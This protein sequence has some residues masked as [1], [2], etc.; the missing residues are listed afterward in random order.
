ML[1]AQSAG[2]PTHTPITEFRAESFWVLGSR[3][4]GLRDL[5]LRG[6]VLRVSGNILGSM[7]ETLAFHLFEGFENLA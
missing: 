6:L 7:S 4:L 5:G 3:A 1:A 2:H